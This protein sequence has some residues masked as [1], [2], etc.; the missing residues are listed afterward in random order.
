VGYWPYFESALTTS[1][2]DAEFT[3]QRSRGTFS[4][5]DKSRQRW[6]RNW[7][8]TF[9]R[10]AT[11]HEASVGAGGVVDSEQVIQNLSELFGHEDTRKTT[12]I[13]KACQ[14]NP[15]KQASRIRTASELILTG[16]FVGV[17]FAVVH[18]LIAFV[19]YF[20]SHPEMFVFA[21]AIFC[22]A[23]LPI[24]VLVGGIALFVACVA[25]LLVGAVA[26]SRAVVF[27]GTMVGL[28]TGVYVGFFLICNQL[29]SVN[30]P[31]WLI[32]TA[33]VIGV[34]FISI[35]RNPWRIMTRR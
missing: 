33:A 1:H 32:A 11:T 22:I 17:C 16:A 2:S 35:F 19:V 14:V 20:G 30:V 18:G 24:G 10:V 27:L 3:A 21:V 13:R 9:K 5:T 29:Y 31:W 15:R 7:A 6:D 4:L 8:N 34:V 23:N 12:P 28:V 25:N 26:A